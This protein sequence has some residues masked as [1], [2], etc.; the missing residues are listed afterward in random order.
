VT[1]SVGHTLSVS[2]GSWSENPT[3]YS[4]QWL[5]CN[6]SGEK[7]VAVSAATKATYLLVSADQG[8]TFRAEVTA[9]N[10]TGPSA[11]AT[12]NQTGVV[13]P[14]PPANTAPPVITGTSAVGQTLSVSDGSWSEN[15]TSYSYQWLRCN[16]LG[17]ECAAI[18][19]ATKAT[20]LLVSADQGTT[21]RAEVTAANSAGP[22]TPATSNQTGVVAPAQLATFGKTTVGGSSDMFLAE[23]KRVNKYTLSAAG[24]VSKLSIYL[25][26]TSTSG[27]QVL[28]GV[29]YEDSAGKPAALLGT[30]SQLT[31][32][33]T[34]SAGWYDLT[35]PSAVSLAAGNYW[36]GMIT[37]A[38]SYVAGFRFDSVSGSRDYNANTYSSG[39]SNPFGSFSA[40][41]EQT[42]LY[43]TY[44]PG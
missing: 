18:G 44:T 12:A 17:E 20:Y 15:P 42:S 43:A 14:L 7:C 23:R 39:P 29:I 10:A 19:G 8:F 32:V 13:Q 27:Q 2:N 3:S 33:S 41:S 26:P 38:S 28:K 1:A 11:P 36:I 37:G 35:F 25:A 4:Y 24:K 9:S 6:S 31:F 21:I 22:S 5:R 30:T 16:T 34:N 40:D